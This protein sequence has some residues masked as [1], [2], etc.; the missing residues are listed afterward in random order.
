MGEKTAISWC[1][2]TWNPWWGC[3]HVSPGCV[4]CYAETLAARYGSDVWG[5]TAPRRTFGDSHW[6]QPLAWN[7]KAER[8]GKRL[9][10]FCASMADVFEPHPALVSERVKLWKL[11]VETPWI[12]WQILTKRPEY[13][14]EM[15]PMRWVVDGFPQNVWLG[16]SVEDQQ[17]ANER[18]LQ[19]ATLPVTSVRFL[20]CEPLLGPVEIPG[21]RG[22][23][24]WVIVGGESGPKHREM[25]LSWLEDIA[26]WCQLTS[27]A[28]WVKQDSGRRSGMQGRIPDRL[29][30]LKQFPE[31]PS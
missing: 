12:D 30:K 10:V 29:W 21:G 22:Y 2:A 13:V 3:A 27:T 20:S 7:R 1:N 9:K 14:P 16:T 25:D 26:D 4:H 18:V 6:R 15:V 11:V 17:R 8:E 19:L 28:L 5:K 24:D 23:V 31:V